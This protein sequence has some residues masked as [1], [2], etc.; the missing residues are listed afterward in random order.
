[1]DFSVLGP[2]QAFLDGRPVDLGVR[3]QRF[4]LAV[5]LLEANKHVP[6]DRLIELTWPEGEA[7]DTARTVIHTQISRLRA[8]FAQSD[9]VELVR[10]G[11]GYQ[12]RLDP[13]RVDVFRFHTLCARARA[14]TDER[15]IELL[16]EALALWK[17]PALSSVATEDVRLRVAA[18]LEEARLGALEDRFEACLRRGRE[19]EIIHELAEAATAHP[20]RQQLVAKL[21]LALHRLDRTPEALATY[22]RLYR[23]LDEELG[24][25]PAPAV[26]QLQVRILRDDPSLLPFTGPRQLPPDV[27]HYTGRDDHLDTLAGLFG[28]GDRVPAVIAITGKPGLGKTALAVRA[29]H[30][31]AA[32]F[33]DG[34]LFVDLHGAGPQP[35]DPAEVLARFL[36]DL[37]VADTDLPASLEER[38]G[39]FRDRCASRHLLVV[40]DNAA[41]E[42]QL[43]SLI[44]GNP[45]CG[46]LITSRR[47]LTGL[48]LRD[49]IDLEG[50]ADAD[51]LALLAGLAPR[52][53]AEDEA[54]REIVRLCGGLPL[55]LRIVGAKLR[56]R[57]HQTV[58]DL[59]AR[60]ADER[61]RLD[62]LVGGDREVRAG[63]LLSYTGLEAGQQRAFRLL[64]AMPDAGFAAWAAAVALGEDLWTTERLL[65]GLVDVN[66][67]ECGRGEFTATRYHFH[68][69]IRLYAREKL[70]SQDHADVWSRLTDAYLYLGKR[71]DAQLEFG[72]LHKFTPPPLALDA[73][74]LVADVERKAP[75]WLADEH[76]SILHAVELSAAAADD[77]TTCRLS[78]T[79]AAFLELRAQWS[80]LKR[81][82]QLSHAAATRMDSPY[83]TSY[84]LF[85]LGLAAREM[86]DFATSERSFRDGLAILPRAED[87]LLEVVTLLSVGVS[88]RLQGRWDEAAAFFAHCLSTLDS[89]DEPRWRAYALR[90]YGV[91]HRYRGKWAEAKEFLTEAIATYRALGD[92]RWA[93]V[94]GREL[95][96]IHQDEGNR[97]AAVE[98]LT[99]SRE[100]L[101][102]AGDARREGAALRCLAWVALEAG[103]F[104]EALAYARQATETLSRTRDAHGLACAEVLLGDIHLALG[105]PASGRAH[106]DR[107]LAYLETSG[108]PRWRGKSM[109]SLGHHLA[110]A[111]DGP[112]ARAAWEKAWEDLTRI[113]AHE[114][115]KVRALLDG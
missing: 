87:P 67:L 41:D 55:A 60:M 34:Q 44:P 95:G 74:R 61:D 27:D 4:V 26:R 7:P 80:D 76:P 79:V 35:R 113:G 50:L 1:M 73:P 106:L 9:D 29:A 53:A 5:L 69:L 52:S 32:R 40:L 17:G 42:E 8:V 94:S 77:A 112:G 57:P 90:E 16:E 65:E 100:A 48:D 91:L 51:A 75:A 71:A 88:H 45:E 21:I 33:P 11:P 23:H 111:G 56:S 47:R 15:R 82:A 12:L 105:D 49:L 107:G 43:R 63:F 109:L 19:A 84:A 114:A 102:D 58:A 14:A 93:A 30:R 54:A 78:A 72:G 97:V 98:Q 13:L 46:V 2:V 28:T 36:R 104:P 70:S 110:A 99:A 83:W 68:D 24:I 18:P 108:D 85:A 64:A 25:E 62:E 103:N 92:V 86:R 31:L 96:I 81:V 37:G 10:E 66:L 22:Q 39:L 101:R 115:A 20:L 6:A 38:I 59:A 89:L 3:K